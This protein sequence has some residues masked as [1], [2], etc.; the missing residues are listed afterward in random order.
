MKI[1]G[2]SE[3]VCPVCKV[4]KDLCEFYKRKGTQHGVWPRCKM[5][6]R[7]RSANWY[8]THKETAREYD[9]AYRTLNPARAKARQ[10]AYH[11]S[12]P[13]NVK[14]VVAAYYTAN[15]DKYIARNA[16]REAIK[17]LAT[18]AWADA[19]AIALLYEEAH[20]LTEETG[21]KHHVDHSVPLRHPRV[22]GLHCEANLR[23]ISSSE[24]QSK[25]NRHWPDMP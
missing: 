18:P 4:T 5:C 19:K 24:N 13:T 6:S 20:R 11:A 14:V 16:M 17:L 9:T 3:K 7:A 10:A 12:N 25:S 2:I 8:S 23:V 21:V 1:I 15:K 22:Q